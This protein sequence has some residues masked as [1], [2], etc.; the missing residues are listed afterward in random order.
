MSS[1]LHRERTYSALR[2]YSASSASTPPHNSETS[3]LRNSILGRRHSI[4]SGSNTRSM[5]AY[6]VT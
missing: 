5:V 6:A 3:N 4:N 2:G 1:L